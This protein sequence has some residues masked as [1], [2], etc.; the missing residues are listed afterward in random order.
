MVI[1]YICGRCATRCL[2]GKRAFVPKQG[3]YIRVLA[4]H[5]TGCWVGER[6]GCV[7]LFDYNDTEQMPLVCTV[8]YRHPSLLDTSYIYI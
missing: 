8:L 6:G 1:L 7:G 3:D 4:S 5:D 2:T